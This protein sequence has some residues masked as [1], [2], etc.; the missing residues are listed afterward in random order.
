M[1]FRM[2]VLVVA[3][4]TTAQAQVNFTKDVAPILESGNG[5]SWKF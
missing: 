5:R 3:F 1:A 4:A 2:A